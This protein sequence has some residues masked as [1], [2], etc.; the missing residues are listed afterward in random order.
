MKD[1]SLL[2]DDLAP[3]RR[4]KVIK[5]KRFHSNKGVS[6]EVAARRQAAAEA[7]AENP[8]PKIQKDAIQMKYGVTPAVIE[9]GIT[10]PKWKAQ[11]IRMKSERTVEVVWQS[12]TQEWFK[13][14][15]GLTRERNSN[16]VRASTRVYPKTPYGTNPYPKRFRDLSSQNSQNKRS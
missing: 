7:H 15:K 9:R 6:A 2:L 16:S 8:L 11:Q 13:A 10:M 5:K 4:V 3:K 1:E 14:T 12:M